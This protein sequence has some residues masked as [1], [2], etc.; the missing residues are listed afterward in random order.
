MV[1]SPRTDADGESTTAVDPIDQ[2]WELDAGHS[3]ET[4]TSEQIDEILYCES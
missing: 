1:V 2:F 4:D 3:G